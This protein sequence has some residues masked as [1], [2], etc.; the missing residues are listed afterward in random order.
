MLIDFLFGD[1]S[2]PL[3]VWLCM[4]VLPRFSIKNPE[5]S[6]GCFFVFSN[7]FVM[8]DLFFLAKQER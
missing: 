7:I 6:F 3:V 8:E 5:G 4:V 1:Q 2:I